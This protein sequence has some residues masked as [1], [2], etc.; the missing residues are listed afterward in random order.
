[1][2]DFKVGDKITPKR[3]QDWPNPQNRDRTIVHI[4]KSWV[5]Y[6]FGDDENVIHIATL[7]RDYEV[8]PD[9][10]EVGKKYRRPTPFSSAFQVR[11][12]TELFEPL[13]VDS[14]VSGDL[15]AFG[16]LALE[17]DPDTYHLAT[18]SKYAWDTCERWTEIE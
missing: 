7:R 2:T 4:G 10:F 11:D 12:V 3:P 15:L 18:F 13:V 16:R 6:D 14:E 17:A 1:M 8:I 9:F 5:L